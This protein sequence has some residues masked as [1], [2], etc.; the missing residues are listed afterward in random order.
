M[1]L[2]N[3]RNKE[4][5]SDI[6]I[7]DLQTKLNGLEPF[8]FLDAKQIREIL[9]RNYINVN[10]ETMSS[11][12]CKIMIEFLDDEFYKYKDK[13]NRTDINKLKGAN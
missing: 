10:E 11:T 13:K 2:F 8:R 3:K 4:D 9:N 12:V 5:L 6:L 1:N 7:K